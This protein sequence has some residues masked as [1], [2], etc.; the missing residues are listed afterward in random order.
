MCLYHN[1]HK[2]TRTTKLPGNYLILISSRS[3]WHL[4]T[5]P[6]TLPHTPLKVTF[7]TAYIYTCTG[8]YSSETDETCMEHIPNISVLKRDRSANPQQLSMHL[9][10]W[11]SDIVTFKNYFLMPMVNTDF[12][13]SSRPYIVAPRTTIGCLM[14]NMNRY[15]NTGLIHLYQHIIINNVTNSSFSPSTLWQQHCGIIGLNATSL[16][17]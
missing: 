11:R 17:S 8:H 2:Q 5:H 12:C 9:V 3:L 16:S 1:K 6:P 15:C 10:P 7:V 4:A 13:F 14:N